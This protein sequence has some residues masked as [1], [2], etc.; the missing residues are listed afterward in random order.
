MAID[1]CKGFTFVRVVKRGNSMGVAP[2]M[3]SKGLHAMVLGTAL[4]LCGSSVASL[5]AQDG[6]N[7]SAVRSSYPSGLEVAFEWQYSCPNGRGCSFSCPG[8]GGASSVTKLSI[9]L[10]SIPLNSPDHAAGVFY[11]F[12]TMQITHANGFAL[13]TG[14][15]TL[16]CQVQGMNL[17]YSGA[18]DMPTGSTPPASK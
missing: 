18:R 5:R 14:I 11:D 13:A 1:P 12:S 3:K 6:N 7:R 16:S 15:S 2:Q 8:S 17:D 4:L 9:Y 10:G